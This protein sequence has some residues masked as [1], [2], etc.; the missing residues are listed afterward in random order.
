M[1]PITCVFI[2][3]SLDGFISR[4]DGSID[5]LMEANQLIPPGE[6]CG[7]GD[8]WASVD[9]LVVGRNTFEQVLTF[10]AWPYENKPVFVLT[11]RPLDIPPNL[12][13]QVSVS[14]ES[15]ADLLDRLSTAGIK[16]VYVDGG[17]T[18]QRFLAADLIDEMTITLIPILL[19]TGRPLF[20]S[21]QV[22]IPFSHISTRSYDFG[23]V[24]NAYR[25]RPS[26][27]K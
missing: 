23:F 11:S 6:D 19:G 17:V 8:F 3:T 24:Q 13:G 5:W 16:R 1:R 9:A 26:D 10:D 27:K 4:P 18:I 21:L 25:R 15:P 12:A 14:S 2:A 20:S 7:Y 22:E